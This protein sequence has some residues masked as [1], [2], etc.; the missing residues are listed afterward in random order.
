MY[1]S[2]FSGYDSMTDNQLEALL[3][4]DL[5]HTDGELLDADEILYI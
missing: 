1:K 4:E 5:N 3:L 2:D